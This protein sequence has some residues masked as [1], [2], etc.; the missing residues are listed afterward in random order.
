MISPGWSV[1]GWALASVC[2]VSLLSFSGVL[3]TLIFNR[4]RVQPL[5]FILVGVAVGAMF[6]DTFIHLL[7][8]SFERSPSPLATSLYCLAGLGIFF[9]LEKFLLWRHDHAAEHTHPIHPV[10]FI[11]L[12][13]DG[14]HNFMDGILIGA[15]YLISV[16]IG[17]ATTIA[18][19]FHEIP[20]EIGDFGVLLYAG[21]SPARALWLNFLTA[22]LAIA[23]TVLSLLIGTR[24]SLFSSA[25]LPLTAGG[26]IYIAGSDLVPELHK[27]R[28]LGQ[29]AIQLLAIG[30]GIGLMLLLK[31]WGRG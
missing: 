14:L 22:T 24:L 23:G 29:A 9:I 16:P 26:F 8:E 18:V 25:M 7:P 27:E 30:G 13:A 5:V 12:I 3:V 10:G 17:V 2:I 1:W 20:Q 6:G 31:L 4:Q 15:S 11:N 21:F 28:Q 19:C